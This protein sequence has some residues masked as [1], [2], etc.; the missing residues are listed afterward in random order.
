[1]DAMFLLKFAAGPPLSVVKTTNVSSSIPSASSAA[2]TLPM[3]S[4]MQA[5]M[6]ATVRRCLSEIVL[7]KRSSYSGGT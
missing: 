6:P 3:A 2:V 4:S 1:M 7:L 5:I